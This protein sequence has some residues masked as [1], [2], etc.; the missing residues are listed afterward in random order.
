M[1]L[2]S[3]V[4][5]QYHVCV[6]A[7]QRH[8]H[9]IIQVREK[10]KLPQLAEI[11]LGD[12]QCSWLTCGWKQAFVTQVVACLVV[13]PVRQTCHNAYAAYA[14]IHI[15]YLLHIQCHIGT[16][17]SHASREAAML[18]SSDW[19]FDDNKHRAA[20]MW[21]DIVCLLSVTFWLAWDWNTFKRYLKLD[22]NLIFCH[23]LVGGK[24]DHIG[25]V[26]FALLP[27][28]NQKRLDGNL[29]KYIPLKWKLCFLPSIRAL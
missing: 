19:G 13:Q 21:F 10:N 8:D 28:E 24:H 15:V 2:V 27:D 9:K 6:C 18:Y 14:Q 16:H 3:L 17:A 29:L 25:F 20:C 5:A 4:M 11:H 7:M 12:H 22:L 1:G 26:N 23:W